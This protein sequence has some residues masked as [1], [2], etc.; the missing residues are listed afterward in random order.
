[1]WQPGE[2]FADAANGV[3]VAVNRALPTGFE[4]TIEV[5]GPDLV[6]ASVTGVPEVPSLVLPGGSFV[7][8]DTTRN[9][10][11][12]AAGPSTTRYRLSPDANLRTGYVA[13]GGVREVPAL[14]P[15][16]GS[17]G[18]ATV[19]VPRATPPGT[20]H[21]GA[22]ADGGRA[23]AEES[24]ANNCRAAAATIRIAAP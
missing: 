10:G 9:T 3:R 22:C 17:T 2:V 24:E 23:V 12:L 20:Y 4:V 7:V 11:P 16:Q 15:G 14:A 18:R 19:R 1:M 5:E 13:L 8:R 21:L 6:V